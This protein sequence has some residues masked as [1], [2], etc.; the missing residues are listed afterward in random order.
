MLGPESLFSPRQWLHPG[1]LLDQAPLLLAVLSANTILSLIVT[2]GVAGIRAKFLP[3]ER[4]RIPIRLMLLGMLL[5]GF[6]PVLIALIGILSPLLGHHQL[7]IRGRRATPPPFAPEIPVYAAHFGAAGASIRLRHGGDDPESVRALLAIERHKSTYDVALLREAMG[8]SSET[9]RLLAYS[10][11]DRRESTIQQLIY[12][13]DSALASATGTQAAMLHRELAGLH[14]ELIYQGLSRE[15]LATHH[16]EQASHH[17]VS[18][19]PF[20]SAD[21]RLALI[22]SQLALHQGNSTRAMEALARADRAGA[23]AARV[24]AYRAE[25]AWK[26]HDYAEVKRQLASN[27]LLACL[28]KIGPVI[29]RWRKSCQL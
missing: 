21:S 3:A 13:L 18:A 10:S 27:P 2:I 23:A 19:R 15:T 22:E 1:T 6:G 17:L 12:R 26:A 5:P 29:Q 9:L 16:L 20:Y 7:W 4:P 8:A 24:I 28:P 11:L 14:L 25:I